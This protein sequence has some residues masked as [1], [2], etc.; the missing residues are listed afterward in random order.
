ME[1]TDACALREE[2]PLLDMEYQTRL[3]K[4]DIL[5]EHR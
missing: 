3:R 4:D 2:A 1:H 5:R